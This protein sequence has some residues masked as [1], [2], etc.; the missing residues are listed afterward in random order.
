MSTRNAEFVLS[1]LRPG[2]RLRRA[3]RAGRATD[4]VFLDDYA[5]L[6]LGLIELYQTDFNP[7]WFAAALELADE[8]IARFEDE[9]GG[10]FDT[11]AGGE[12]LPVRPKQVEDNATPSGNSL[13]AEALLKLAAFTDRGDLRDRAEK[14]LRLP[15]EYA[16]RYPTAF[17][18]WLASAQF[19]LAQVKQVALVGEAD[20]TRPLV[21]V[22]R[23]RHRPAL[24]AACGRVPLDP[25]SPALLRDRPLVNGGATAYVCEG[26]VCQRP[27]TTAEE[28]RQL[29][30]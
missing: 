18:R 28:L 4:E 29:L 12:S 6:I 17:A 27:V 15:V 26:F 23:E 13:A 20:K 10:F 1:N 30:K 5:A 24:V 7:R 22:V 14:A 16:A 2:G 25:E 19:A 3:W 21:D 8:M 9:A 11:P